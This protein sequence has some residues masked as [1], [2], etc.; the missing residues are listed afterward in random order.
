MDLRDDVETMS[1]DG[2]SGGV[3]LPGLSQQQLR[4]VGYFGVWPNLLISPHP[5]YVL[6]HRLEALAPDRTFVECEWL[7]PPRRSSGPGSLPTTPWTSG[8]SRI[9]R[10]GARAS[11]SNEA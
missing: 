3:P 10:T 5:D 4:E 9:A 8:T 6:T 7:F 1:L 11:R 2:R